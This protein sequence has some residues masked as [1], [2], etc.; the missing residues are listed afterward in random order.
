MLRTTTNSFWKGFITEEKLHTQQDFGNFL[1]KKI[2]TR[3][4]NSQNPLNF[5][6]DERLWALEYNYN[7]LPQSPIKRK[8]ERLRANTIFRVC[9][10]PL[11]NIFSPVCRHLGSVLLK[12]LRTPQIL[13]LTGIQGLRSIIIP[14]RPKNAVERKYERLG[15]STIFRLC[16]I[17]L[18]NIILPVCRHSTKHP[19]QCPV[20]QRRTLSAAFKW[21]RSIIIPSRPKNAVE[22]KYE[23]LRASTIFRVCFIPKKNIISPVCRNFGSVLL[24]SLRT[25]KILTL[26]GI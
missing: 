25:P 19:L 4:K 3:T 14:P 18:K 7:P 8:Y 16:F 11:K 20:F 12:S 5:H 13:T 15:A 1:S 22:R 23:R 10:I 17:P 2:Q 24:K 6:A 26:T 9:F 21:V